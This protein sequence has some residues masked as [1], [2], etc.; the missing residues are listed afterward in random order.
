ME[1]CSCGIAGYLVEMLMLARSQ[2]SMMAQVIVAPGRLQLVRDHVIRTHELVK[3]A[4]NNPFVPPGR[5][6]LYAEAFYAGFVGDMPKAVHILVH[7]LEHSIRQILTRTGALTTKLDNYQIQTQQNL[8]KL[9]FRPELNEILGE[10]LVFALQ[11]LLV[12]SFGSNLRNRVAHGLMQHDEFYAT[13]CLY[14]WWLC[15]RICCVSMV[16]AAVE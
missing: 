10:D 4:V 14:F 13:D 3:L 6:L 8:N 5:E 2:Q 15:I 7:Q 11:V 12:E 9:L 16:E 1:A